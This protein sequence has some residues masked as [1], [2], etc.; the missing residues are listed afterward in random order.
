M[1]KSS[2]EGELSHSGLPHLRG[3]CVAQSMWRHPWF[4]DI[5]PFA[6][7]SKHTDETGIGKRLLSLLTD[8]THQEDERRGG[9]GRALAHD[10]GIERFQRSA[11]MKINCAL[12]SGF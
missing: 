4:S 7:A 11:V 3:M 6:C 12:R 2:L 9:I 5:C 1:T 8:S 10:I